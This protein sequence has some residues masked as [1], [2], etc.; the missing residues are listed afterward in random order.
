MNA[1]FDIL[2]LGRV[3]EHVCGVSPGAQSRYSRSE[4]V[5]ERG[6]DA[7]SELRVDPADGQAYSFFQF[8]DYYG[9]LAEHRWAQSV[10]VRADPADAEAVQGDGGD[11]P[12]SVEFAL[13]EDL[14][15]RLLKQRQRRE[16]AARAKAKQRIADAAEAARERARRARHWDQVYGQGSLRSQ[17]RTLEAELNIAYDRA[18]D[19]VGFEV[20]PWPITPLNPAYRPP[21]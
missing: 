12:D 13:S 14:L 11:G 20:K 3:L 19:S 7:S 21:P 8:C 17:I 2:A 5:N 1:T 18:V 15:K 9:D 10:P 4:P 16:R 6:P